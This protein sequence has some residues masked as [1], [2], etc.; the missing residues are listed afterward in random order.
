MSELSVLKGRLSDER[1]VEWQ[2]LPDIELYKDQVLNYM[3]RQHILQSQDEYLTGAMI[4]N[5]IKIGLLPRANGKKYS[6]EH[7]AYL[8]AICALK[9]VLSVT[10]TDLL[11]KR[12]IG[13]ESVD[14]FYEK[15]CSLLDLSLNSVKKQLGSDTGEVK[16]T[17]LAFS[18]AISSYA[19]K[20]VCE[21]ILSMLRESEKEEAGTEKEKVKDKLKEKNNENDKEP[22]DKA[23]KKAEKSKK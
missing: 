10:D 13:S 11:L 21:R 2:E 19:Q 7:L 15:Y 4:N 18:L 3:E 9:Q 12:E 8:T 17:E 22:D 6:K 16:L 14:S 1:P 23:S 5:Y 20:M